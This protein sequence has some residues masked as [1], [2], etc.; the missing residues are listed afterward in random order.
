MD[1]T[2][3][4]IRLQGVRLSFGRTAILNGID[5]E[6][7][8]GH[9]LG[10]T[11]PNG[12]GKTSLL[13][14]IMGLLRPAAGSIEVFGAERRNDADFAEVRRRIG[15]QFQ[16]PDDQ[17]FCPTVA[18]DVAFGPLNLGKGRDDALD[19]VDR[20]LKQVGLSDF[21]DRVIHHLS[22]GEKRLVSL[23]TVLAMEPEVL[24]LDEPTAGLDEVSEARIAGILDGLDQAMIIVSHDRDF[25]RK[26]VHSMSA[27]ADGRLSPVRL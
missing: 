1:L 16:D 18:E 20:V 2:A 21:H 5:L 19:I 6:L 22:E 8:L 25:L 12:S 13:H 7:P 27:L 3:P 4:L 15:F 23:A 9:R 24:L 26:L 17:L 11:G 10:L 14:V